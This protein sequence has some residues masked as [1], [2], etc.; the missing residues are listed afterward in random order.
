[1]I[2]YYTR[3]IQYLAKRYIARHQPII[4]GV[5]GSAGKSSAVTAIGA[6]LTLMLSDKRVYYPSRQLNGELGLPLTIFQIE[7]FGP[8]VKYVTST[9]GHIMMKYMSR[10]KPYDIIVL[11]YGVDHVGEMDI[12]VD[13]ARPDYGVIINIDTVHFGDPEI[14]RSEKSKM[15][16][17]VKNR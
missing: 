15:I 2:K 11:E 7:Y 5:T 17:A 4:V 8:T 1:M 3:L 6:T 12:L 13:I 16:Q 10:T 14:T 9:L